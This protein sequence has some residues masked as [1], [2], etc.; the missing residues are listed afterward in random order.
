MGRRQNKQGESP[1][2]ERKLPSELNK[3]LQAP[4][5]VNLFETNTSYR[6]GRYDTFEFSSKVTCFAFSKDAPLLAVGVEIGGVYLFDLTVPEASVAAPSEL[7]GVVRSMHFGPQNG[8]GEQILYGAFDDGYIRRWLIRNMT[9]M[10]QID[11]LYFGQEVQS[12]LVSS[13]GRSVTAIGK[14]SRLAVWSALYDNCSSY[15]TI[16]WISNGE[17]Y[18]DDGVLLPDVL[19]HPRAPPNAEVF[20]VAVASPTEGILIFNVIVVEPQYT[21]HFDASV[22]PVRA[23][24]GSFS[25]LAAIPQ[26]INDQQVVVLAATVADAKD[27]VALVN[28]QPDAEN[29][30]GCQ[31]YATL[32]E[33]NVKP[34]HAITS[35]HWVNLQEEVELSVI[36]GVS[37]REPQSTVTPCLSPCDDASQEARCR[38]MVLCLGTDK[39]SILLLECI[40]VHDNTGTQKQRFRVRLVYD[41][42]GNRGPVSLQE[43][44]S[45]VVMGRS[46]F[47]SC[48]N[49]TMCHLWELQEVKAPTTVDN[50][51]S[52]AAQRCAYLEMLRHRCMPEDSVPDSD[53]PFVYSSDQG[54]PVELRNGAS[55][56]GHP[57][58]SPLQGRSTCEGNSPFLHSR[59]D[60]RTLCMPR[61]LKQAASDRQK[62]QTGKAGVD[63]VVE[64][65]LNRVCKD[66]SLWE[67]QKR[68]SRPRSEGSVQVTASSS[69]QRERPLRTHSE[70]REKFSANDRAPWN[71]RFHVT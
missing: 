36:E 26:Q 7:I 28:L 12:L 51:A 53:L 17:A 60:G 18:V 9:E 54:W 67:K 11:C 64:E 30:P 10:I 58:L 55:G 31:V 45:E 6:P 52:H 1:Q 56:H 5:D 38:R 14:Q 27:Q 13:G 65:V 61:S 4:A 16:P 46:I 23:L 39:G 47:A 34:E 37:S 71:D 25:K 8:F 43:V 48:C 70:R 63:A 19:L 44:P 21:H 40:H 24:P 29:Y 42:D 49:D 32:V 50:A 57:P 62:Q 3:P 41:L 69:V 33:I 20:H 59:R 22:L 68:D 35:I 66:M 2:Q 15:L